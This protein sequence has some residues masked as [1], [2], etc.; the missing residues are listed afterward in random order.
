MRHYDKNNVF[1]RILRREIPASILYEDEYAL[2]F[3]DVHPHAPLHVLIIPK[4]EFASFSDF[5]ALATPDLIAGLMR[6]IDTVIDLLDLRKNGFRLIIN[7][8][9][10]GGQEVPHYHVHL[11]GGGPLGPLTSKK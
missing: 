6:A 1:A 7:Q 8:G 3:H 5:M 4:G 10:D 11:L 9:S 2:A